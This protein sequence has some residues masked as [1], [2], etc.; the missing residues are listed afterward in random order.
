MGSRV[1]PAFEGEH[2]TSDAYTE[3]GAEC[4]KDAGFLVSIAQK[5]LLRK[6]RIF[7]IFAKKKVS[8]HENMATFVSRLKIGDPQT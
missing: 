1:A 4:I 6:L 7:S 8:Q 2:I 3:L 5:T